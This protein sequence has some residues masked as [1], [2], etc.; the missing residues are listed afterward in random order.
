MQLMHISISQLMS[1]ISCLYCECYKRLDFINKVHDYN[2]S[3]QPWVLGTN[4]ASSGTVSGWDGEVGCL[5]LP[6]LHCIKPHVRLML[7]VVA[8]VWLGLQDDVITQ[9]GAVLLEI[10]VWE[11]GTDL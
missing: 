3:Y 5:H 10:A 6:H 1:F 11:P 4:Q 9:E 2:H 7:N 8:V